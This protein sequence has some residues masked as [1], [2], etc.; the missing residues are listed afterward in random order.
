MPT[1]LTAADYES[2]REITSDTT[3]KDNS[4]ELPNC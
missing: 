1:E 4:E 2:L 3:L